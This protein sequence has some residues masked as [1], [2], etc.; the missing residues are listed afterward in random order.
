MT[1]TTVSTTI[2]S[3]QEQFAKVGIESARLD[4]RLL[5]AHVLEKT[6]DQLRILDDHPIDDPKAG[7][8]ERLAKRRSAREPMSHILG[9]REFWSLPFRIDHNVLTPR[10]ETETIV[11]AALECTAPEAVLRVVDLGTGSGC[12]L[13]SIL[14]ERPNA[15][16]LGI[17]I[18]LEACRIARENAQSLGFADRAA[19]VQSDWS[20]PIGK[21]FDL[22]VCNPPY[23]A[24]QEIVTLAPEVGAYEP[25]LALR[26]GEDG[27]DAY[28]SL[29]RSLATA[30]KP[31]AA[32]I[33]EI[34]MGQT[35]SVSEIL[36]TAGL[37]VTRVLSDLSGTERC[38]FATVA[39]LS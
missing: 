19:F 23:I 8:I 37:R 13:L 7:E 29:A 14:S 2:N 38:L 28:R 9:E 27:L 32:A 20:K 36:G 16:G 3:L 25:Q 35:T 11:E 17:D 10:P 22:V 18:D 31:R 6:P 4:S 39:G 21:P 12:I 26:G 33:I 30:L 15:W 34:G 1:A 24:D 5:V